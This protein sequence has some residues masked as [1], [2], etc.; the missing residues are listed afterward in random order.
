MDK[1]NPAKPQPMEGIDEEKEF[2]KKLE[3]VKTTNPALQVAKKPT[4]TKL[5]EKLGMSPDA[6]RSRWNLPYHENEPRIIKI[7][8]SM[9]LNR[10]I[11]IRGVKF[12][13]AI[14]LSRESPRSAGRLVAGKLKRSLTSN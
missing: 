8:R 10:P 7:N 11:K 6:I 9:P 1:S 4:R 12:I 5:G 13:G 3:F 14:K 2:L